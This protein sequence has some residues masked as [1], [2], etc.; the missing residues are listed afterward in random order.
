MFNSLR[1]RICAALLSLL[2]ACGLA[3]GVAPSAS[4]DI[5]TNATISYAVFQLINS[6]RAAN[7]L[8]A[9]KSDP[10]LRAAAHGHNVTMAKYNTLSHQLPGEP[11]FNVR[12]SNTGFHCGYCGE[13]VGW[14]SDRSQNGGL[15]LEV[16]MYNEKAPNNG[17]RLN[18]LSTRYNYVG[19]DVIIDTA[20]GKLW[21]TED[22]A[23]P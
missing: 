22:F 21:L 6:E 8:P 9:L 19:V 10:H 14:N 12:I 5:P 3:V 23:H 20:H 2:C 17:H 13:N 1:A 18:I 15:A 11:T 16:S 4:A 7:H